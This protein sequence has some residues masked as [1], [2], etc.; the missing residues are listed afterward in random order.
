[1]ARHWRP[2]FPPRPALITRGA[3][4]ERANATSLANE[5]WTKVLQREVGAQTG[6]G[7]ARF[8]LRGLWARDARLGGI[9]AMTLLLY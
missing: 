2:G 9:A 6:T 7:D 3:C 5:G 8:Q 4:S 1:M